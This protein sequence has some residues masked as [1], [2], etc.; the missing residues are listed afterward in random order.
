MNKLSEF[1]D[2]FDKLVSPR[3]SFLNNEYVNAILMIV[4][5]AY[6]SLAA[7]R[8]PRSVAKLFDSPITK[9]IFFFLI[10]YTAKHN[11]GVA[12]IAAI[13]VLVSLMTLNRYVSAEMM[14][15]LGTMEANL[16][17]CNGWDCD[18]VPVEELH[19]VHDIEGHMQQLTE[20]GY[21][22]DF[23]VQ[24]PMQE[25]VVTTTVVEPEAHNIVQPHT[26]QEE[27]NKQVDTYVEK[28]KG[29]IAKSY[30]GVKNI[31]KKANIIEGFDDSSSSYS[32][33]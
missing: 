17:K 7:P 14:S 3:I 28:G 13:A 30:E 31:L 9:L 21:P 16:D 20:D 22:V 15:N 10:V 4:L 18:E 27:I 8:L 26:T 19:A 5:I 32:E 25:N 2:S 1:S 12:I 6:A 24:Q 33:F 29:V 23:S 11:A